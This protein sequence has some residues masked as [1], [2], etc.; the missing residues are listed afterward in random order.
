MISRCNKFVKSYTGSGAEETAMYSMEPGPALTMKG[1]MKQFKIEVKHA[2]A[3]QLLTIAAELKIMS[4]GWEKYGPRIL[5]NGQK[6][7]A[8]ELHESRTKRQASS[9]KRHNMA[10]FI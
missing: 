5:I 2:S 9:V 1:N 8:P 7:Q 3:A 10:R 6:L 4:N